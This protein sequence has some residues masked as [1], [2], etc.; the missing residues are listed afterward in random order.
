M[1]RQISFIAIGI[2]AATTA[3]GLATAGHLPAFNSRET[4]PPVRMADLTGAGAARRVYCYS[5]IKGAPGSLYRGWVCELE[6]APA[7]V[8]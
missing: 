4:A 1:K 5:G 2:V 3:L 6:H 8:N 7:S